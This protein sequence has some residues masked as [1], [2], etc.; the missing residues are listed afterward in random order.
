MMEG[1]CAGS[2]FSAYVKMQVDNI[3]IFAYTGGAVK[4]AFQAF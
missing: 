1:A 2:F 3:L 4:A